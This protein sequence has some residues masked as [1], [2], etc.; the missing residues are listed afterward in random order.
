[1]AQQSL[2]LIAGQ[3]MWPQLRQDDF[4]PPGP[5]ETT[6][7]DGALTLMLSRHGTAV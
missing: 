5:A 4:I 3:L 7:V 1:M 2:S 6:V